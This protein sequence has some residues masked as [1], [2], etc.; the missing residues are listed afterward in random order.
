MRVSI[1]LSL[2][3]LVALSGCGGGQKT[4]TYSTSQGK[5]TVAGAGAIDVAKLG[6]PLYPGVA[7]NQNSGSIT[8][9]TASGTETMATFETSDPFATVSAWY[10]A[11]LPA[12]SQK[13]SVNEGGTEM[14]EFITKPDT[15]N[16][17]VVT[18]T[19]KDNTTSILIAHGK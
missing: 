4:A 19:G 10:K 15:A 14:A 12:G 17:T 5:V 8:A 3:S 11:H 13:V 9:A 16:Q 6:V 7:Q 18:I 1:V 2:L